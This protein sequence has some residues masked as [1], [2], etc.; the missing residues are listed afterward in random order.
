MSKPLV[1]VGH[2]SRKTRAG[3]E[4]GGRYALNRALFASKWPTLGEL[5]QFPPE[6]Y[7][8]DFSS[9]AQSRGNQTFMGAF[10][11]TSCFFAFPLMAFNL[12]LPLFV[13]LYPHVRKSAFPLDSSV[14]LFYQASINPRPFLC[15]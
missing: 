11:A 6:G 13:N 5:V 8:I 12:L 15:S 4:S 7:G 2:E 10:C 9:D 1:T 3:R 14:Y